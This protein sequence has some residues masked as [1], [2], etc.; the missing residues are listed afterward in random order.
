[1]KKATRWALAFILLV[2]LV[3]VAPPARSEFTALPTFAVATD[4]NLTGASGIYTITLGNLDNAGDFI[5]AVRILPP[6]GYSLNPSLVN[7]GALLGTVVVDGRTF[8]ISG[9][10]GV[11]DEAVV[12]L[13]VGFLRIPVGR[14]V[15]DWGTRE[16]TLEVLFNYTNPFVQA[17]LNTV[18]GLVVNPGVAGTYTWRAWAQARSSHWAPLNPSDVLIEAILLLLHVERPGAPGDSIK[19]TS[20]KLFFKFYRVGAEVTIVDAADVP[21]AGATVTG[22]WSGI[23][24]GSRSAVTDGNGRARINEY[25]YNPIGAA[26]FTVD[27]V[28]KPGWVYDVGSNLETYDTIILP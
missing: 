27:S 16:L 14:V 19:L 8:E 23:F 22:H 6:T 21:V 5:S 9:A 28:T 1:M 4:N 11:G 15:F 24:S 26:T 20:T 7:P 12:L 10:P 3:A 13:V 17:V 2:T 25:R 18:A